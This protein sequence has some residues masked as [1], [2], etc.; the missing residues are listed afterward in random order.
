MKDR[1]PVDVKLAETY[2]DSPFFG[3]VILPFNYWIQKVSYKAMVKLVEDHWIAS[4][5]GK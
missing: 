2:P 1:F 5:G 3:E 4:I